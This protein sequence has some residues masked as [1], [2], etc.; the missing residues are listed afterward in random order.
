MTLKHHD[1]LLSWG[2][3]R[4]GRE[5]GELRDRRS[6]LKRARIAID[7]AE[8][9]VQGVHDASDRQQLGA[10]SRHGLGPHRHTA[11]RSIA[12]GPVQTS[13]GSE[14]E[15]PTSQTCPAHR[16]A[17]AGRQSRIPARLPIE[18]DSFVSPRVVDFSACE[19]A[20]LLRPRPLPLPVPVMLDPHHQNLPYISV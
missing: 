18:P 7:Q 8:G 13:G 2:Q 20:P 11:G 3:Q 15:T 12:G 9:T 14:G 10:H 6:S 5:I 16:N 1:E 4:R 19:E 17:H